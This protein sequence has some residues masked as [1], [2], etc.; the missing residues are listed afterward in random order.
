MVMRTKM[1]AATA[2]A[3]GTDVIGRRKSSAGGPS[4][5]ERKDAH[6]KRKLAL[7]PEDQLKKASQKSELEVLLSLSLLLLSFIINNFYCFRSFLLY[8]R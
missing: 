8:W 1:A 6:V 5:T 7:L 3:A 4:H 2:A